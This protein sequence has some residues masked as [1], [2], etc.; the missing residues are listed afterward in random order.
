LLTAM[1]L[2]Q[3]DYLGGQ[4]SRGSGQIVFNKLGVRLLVGKD[5]HT[6]EDEPFKE[7][8]LEKLLEHKK[9]LLD[10]IKETVMVNQ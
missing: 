3:D 10:W 5:Y 1:H 4:G 7:L 9:A 2:V 8:S 6:V